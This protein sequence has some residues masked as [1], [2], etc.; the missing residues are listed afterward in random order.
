MPSLHPAA[1]HAAVT[2][3]NIKT[4]HDGPPYDLFLILRFATVKPHAASAIGTV[5]PCVTEWGGMNA[6]RSPGLAYGPA[7]SDGSWV[8]RAG[9]WCCLSLASSQRDV[10]F[11]TQ[12]LDFLLQPLNLP[13]LLFD[14][15]LRPVPLLLRDKLDR[16][17][18]SPRFC[19]LPDTLIHHTVARTATLFSEIFQAPEFTRLSGR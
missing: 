7:A 16:V 8:L 14:L 15:L 9:M 17:S 11:L 12:V 13:L 4:A 3:S 19:W 6:G 2:H 18:C 5:H 10:Q 1:T